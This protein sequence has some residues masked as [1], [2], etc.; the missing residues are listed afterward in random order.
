[1]MEDDIR[2]FKIAVTTASGLG[3]IVLTVMCITLPYYKN[4]LDSANSAMELEYNDIMVSYIVG[5]QTCTGV[6]R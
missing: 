4:L 1:M 2:Q 3:T 6:S 5:G